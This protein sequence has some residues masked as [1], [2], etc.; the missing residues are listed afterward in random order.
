M[1]Q[2]DPHAK[3]IGEHEFVMYML[4]PM[5]SHDL[6][7]DVI[8]MV[9]PGLGPVFDA[10]GSKAKDKALSDLLSEDL[11]SDFFT[12]AA[13]TLFSGLRK[14][15]LEKSIKALRKVTQIDGKSLDSTFDLHFLGRL[16]L[17]YQWLIWGFQVQWGKAFGALLGGIGQQGAV[18]IP[19]FGKSPSPSTSTG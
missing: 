8:Q 9:G 14:D 10:L 11:T 17:M 15:V 13:E 12:K 19:R 18:G 16:D 7:M 4:P 6:L 5:Q 1:S 2:A 3:T